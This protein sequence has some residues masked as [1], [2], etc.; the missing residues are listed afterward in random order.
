MSV[1][2]VATIQGGFMLSRAHQNPSCVATAAAGMWDM[3]DKLR[4]EG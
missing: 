1:P 3:L 2:V 4:R